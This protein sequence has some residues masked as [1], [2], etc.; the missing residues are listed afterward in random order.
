M[1][2][3][4]A[5]LEKFGLSGKEAS[6]YLSCLELGEATAN[7][8][9]IKSHLPRTLVYDIF[10][11]L[12]E[13]GLASTIIK[14]KTKRFGVVK[15]EDLLRMIREKEEALSSVLEEMKKIQQAPS[16]IPKAEVFVGAEGVKSVLDAVLKAKPKELCVYGSSATSFEIMPTYIPQWHIRRTRLNIKMRVIYND[17]RRARARMKNYPGTTELLEVRFMPIK[18]EFPTSF[19]IYNNKLIMIYWSREPLTILIESKGIA[20]NHKQYFEQLWKIAE[21][22]K[23]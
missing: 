15:P 21:V 20:A 9:A 4:K 1:E 19:V 18:Y 22:A 3:I 11:R 17:V 7:D 8:I 23:S 13:K 2:S 14:E 16:E 6:V 5:A 12:I 10:K